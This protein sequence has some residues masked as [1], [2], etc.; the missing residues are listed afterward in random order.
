[1]HVKLKNEEELLEFAKE[2]LH[3]SMNMRYWQEQWKKHYGHSLLE[4]KKKWEK[5]YDDFVIKYQVARTVHKYDVH[6]KIE[7]ND[8]EKTQA[9]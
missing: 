2:L 1:M 3:I 4:Q 7:N 8:Q 5:R 6:I 9:T